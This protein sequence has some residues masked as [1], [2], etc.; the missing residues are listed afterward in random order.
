MGEDKRAEAYAALEVALQRFSEYATDNDE[1]ITDAVLLVAAQHVDDDGDRCGRV[2]VF[3][4]HG[5]QPI[6]ITKGML[7]DTLDMM[8]NTQ[9]IE[10]RGD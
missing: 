9:Q 10:M 8:R 6:Y 4:R 3:P 7:I 5:Y 2:F 1:V